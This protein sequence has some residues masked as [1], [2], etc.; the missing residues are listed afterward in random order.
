MT[1]ARVIGIVAPSDVSRVLE[2][3]ELTPRRS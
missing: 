1:N 2:R 3:T